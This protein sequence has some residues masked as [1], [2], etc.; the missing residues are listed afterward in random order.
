MQ[1]LG[2]FENSLTPEKAIP[3][4]LRIQRHKISNLMAA[5]WFGCYLYV[6][7]LLAGVSIHFITYSYNHK[8]FPPSH[9]FSAQRVMLHNQAYK[10]FFFYSITESQ[11]Y[12]LNIVKTIH[13]H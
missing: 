5:T 9:T 6:H 11:A 13:A 2:E 7:I 4:S 3:Y 12:K 1:M 8:A 10:V